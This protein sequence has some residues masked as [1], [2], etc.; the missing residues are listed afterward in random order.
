MSLVEQQ[1]A[2]QRSTEALLR[3]VQ[4]QQAQQAAVLTR[5]MEHSAGNLPSAG[6]SAQT[7]G[8]AG[9]GFRNPIGLDQV[10]AARDTP[11]DRP[12]RAQDRE[13][14]LVDPRG[15]AWPPVLTTKVA[16][17]PSDFKVWRTKFVAWASAQFPG[18]ERY[19]MELE[20]ATQVEFT[21]A[22]LE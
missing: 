3:S 21:G 14:T 10:R 4:D 11:I 12:P 20:K 22:R 18:G 7:N 13:P 16:E 5:L 17:K 2:A 15:V 6:G 1:A 9:P 19:L 8:A